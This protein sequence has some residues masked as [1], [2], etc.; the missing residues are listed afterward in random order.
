VLYADFFGGLLEA[1]GE[2]GD[3]KEARH[4]TSSRQIG[5]RLGQEEYQAGG[6]FLET[7]AEIANDL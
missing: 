3:L 1:Q 5:L 4:S 2:L 6:Q 7:T